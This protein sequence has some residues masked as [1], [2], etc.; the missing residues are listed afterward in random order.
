M[1]Q[2]PSTDVAL[3]AWQIA[4]V[5]SQQT[6]IAPRLNSMFLERLLVQQEGRFS[7]QEVKRGLERQGR[8]AK[9]NMAVV[10][11]Q[12]IRQA[13]GANAT[14]LNTCDILPSSIGYI[15]KTY[16]L[17]KQVASTATLDREKFRCI[18]ES[19]AELSNAVLADFYNDLHE[20]LAAALEGL[21]YS[22]NGTDF[23]Y[24]GSLPALNNPG[25]P[26]PYGVLPLLE[27]DGK[28]V[29]PAGLMSFQQD[30]MQVGAG[31]NY[32][33]LGNS[34]AMAYALAQKM[35]VPNLNGYDLTVTKEMLNAAKIMNSFMIANAFPGIDN[36]L[37]VIEDG[38]LAFVSEPLYP[39]PIEGNGQRMWS[40][41]H[42][43]LPGVWINITETIGTVCEANT[44]PTIQ[45]VGTIVFNLIGKMTCDYEGNF[46]SEGNRGVYLY[47]IT[48]A[49]GGMCD[50]P[51]RSTAFPNFI[52]P[53]GKDCTPE[54]V[55]D[56]ACRLDRLQI[57]YNSIAGDDYAVFTVV[58]TPA[59]GGSQPTGY[60]WSINGSVVVGQTQNSLIVDL[61]GLNDGD[62]VTV[63][64][65]GSAD[66]TAV[67]AFEPFVLP[68]AFR[69]IL[70][71]TNFNGG[72]VLV[73]GATLDL[74]SIEQDG[75]LQFALGVSALNLPVVVATI[76]GSASSILFYPT[77]SLPA[78]LTVGAP[79][80][81]VTDV[82]DTTV[83]GVVNGSIT[84]TS[85]ATD[86]IFVINYT[87][88]VT[89]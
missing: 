72:A 75:V 36:P 62:V 8:T 41:Q 85:N 54:E 51:N 68:D 16:W 7:I 47:D 60:V 58:F 79:E 71:V 55:C 27:A 11:R 28:T 80:D 50:L 24:I 57:G 77:L 39:T 87:Y 49:D 69:G 9:N 1:P 52:L 63:E 4:Y 31:N 43:N 65:I 19:D 78:T 5:K 48:C 26:R 37:L 66:C 44:A 6:N 33:A 46:F 86:D 76:A 15:N 18:Q 21:L 61:S 45:W 35:Q 82:L 88:T 10:L 23:N 59:A 67:T 83:L 30:M 53:Y 40:Q 56:T 34:R 73:N 89:V 2:V 12:R 42:P 84:I 64:A 81:F 70:R 29:N 25:A 22:T 20:K 17:D 74:G 32:F 13:Y 38:A 14:N 3:S